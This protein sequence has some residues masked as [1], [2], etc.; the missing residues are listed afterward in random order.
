MGLFDIFKSKA[1]PV[2]EERSQTLEEILL[3]AGVLKNAISKNQALSIPSVSASVDLIANTVASIPV[4]LY[5]ETDGKVTDVNDNRTF[6]IN[7]ETGDTLNGF[8]FKKSLVIDYLINGESYAYINRERNKIKS[9]HYVDNNRVSVLAS[10]SAIFKSY[11]LL[12]DGATY[13]DFE[14]VKVLR[15]TKDGAT[16]TGI[17]EQNNT[18][19]SVA[20]YSLL[21][22]NKLIGRGGNKK[23]FLQAEDKLS[24]ETMKALKEAWN[25]LYQNDNE[26]VMVLNEGLKFQE[27][28]A[29]SVELQLNENKQTNANEISK[30]FN[31][32]TNILN[33]SFTKDEYKSFIKMTIMPILKAI[34][35]AFNKDLLLPSEKSKS[36]YFA[37]DTSQLL[38]GDDEDRFKAY[39]EA[40]KGGWISKNEV[41]Y[42]EDLPPIEG[43]DIVTMSLGDVI[44]DVKTGKYFTPNMDST[45]DL[46]NSKGGEIDE[47]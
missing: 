47:N 11:E 15:N 9:L 10:P 5:Q 46:E 20:Y 35:T 14:F 21:F 29:T 27:S 44:F 23:G 32:P 40:I 30:I 24:E 38:K 4:Y 22:E 6:L 16:G 19:L 33:G 18:L 42:R 25:R 7:D 17:I 34:E 13:R 45:N 3:E 2:K 12:V 39:S 28:S 26:N 43:L 36:F 31:I 37:F 41:R 1:E 8:D